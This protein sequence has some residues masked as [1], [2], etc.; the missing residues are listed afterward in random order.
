MEASPKISQKRTQ[1]D[2]GKSKTKKDQEAKCSSKGT[3]SNEEKCPKVKKTKDHKAAQDPSS[4]EEKV[5]QDRQWLRIQLNMQTKSLPMKVK[6][7]RQ[8][9]SDDLEEHSPARS[10]PYA[11]VVCQKSFAQKSNLVTHFR[12]H[13]GSRPYMCMEYI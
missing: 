8:N 9:L 2:L 6:E 10:R 4:G 13:T 1:E 7:E 5:N 12:V 11:C 3:K